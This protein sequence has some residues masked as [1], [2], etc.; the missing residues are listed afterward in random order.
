MRSQSVV[1][2]LRKPLACRLTSLWATYT[3]SIC[4]GDLHNRG[5]F[6]RGGHSQVH[7]T[8]GISTDVQV[9]NVVF[10][11][12]F[13][14][15]TLPDAAARA[16]PDVRRC[17][18]LLPHRDDVAICRVVDEDD[19]RKNSLAAL[20]ASVIIEAIVE[21]SLRTARCACVC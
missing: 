6:R 11:D 14:E 2:A 1:A 3:Y 17:E 19:T 13:D 9:G 7:L 16:I 20:P 8:G 21:K 15:H 18:R 4:N 10:W 5:L 12:G